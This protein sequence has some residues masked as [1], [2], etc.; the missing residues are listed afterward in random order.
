MAVEVAVQRAIFDDELGPLA[1]D[2]VGST[3]AWE[4]LLGL[5]ADPGSS[6]WNDATL[7][8]APAGGPGARIGAA[9]DV[10]GAALRKAFGEP[11][12]WTW[13]KLHQ[14]QFKDSTLG[15]SGLLPLELYFNSQAR[16]VAGADGAIDNNYYQVSRAYPDPDDPTSQG[17]GLDQLFDVSNG[18]SYR[19][20]VDMGDLNGARIIITT[21][22]SGNAFDRHAIDLIPLWANGDA[23][24]LPFSEANILANAAETLT[25]TPP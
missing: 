21:G 16:P 5:L 25:L 1:R 20:V 19:L 17:V 8:A 14:V 11:A 24:S 3:M 15:S 22:Q 13:G 7:G 4:S 23:V 12:N 18:P 9:L 6:W 10:T 2:Y